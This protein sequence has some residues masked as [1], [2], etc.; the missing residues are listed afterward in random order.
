[1][2]GEENLERERERGLDWIEFE[3]E[4]VLKIRNDG[5]AV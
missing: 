1:M 4:F 2:E 5:Y 3:F